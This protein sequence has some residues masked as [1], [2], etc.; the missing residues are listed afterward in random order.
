VSPKD[1]RNGG[2]KGQQKER[3]EDRSKRREREKE[4]LGG[5]MTGRLRGLA[6]LRR[7]D[8]HKVTCTANQKKRVQMCAE[9]AATKRCIYGLAGLVYDIWRGGEETPGTSSGSRHPQ[10]D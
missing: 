1:F 7:K 5:R 9:I 2:E 8:G 3:L 4:E 10:P 6:K